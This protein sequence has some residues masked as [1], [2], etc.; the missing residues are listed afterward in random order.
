MRE[1]GEEVAGLCL[2]ELFH[3]DSVNSKVKSLNIKDTVYI[4]IYIYICI[5]R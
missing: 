1:K 4:N 3:F 5:K 2:T